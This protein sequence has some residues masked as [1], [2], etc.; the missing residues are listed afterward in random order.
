MKLKLRLL[1]GLKLN[2]KI[3]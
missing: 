1:V 2:E 3:P